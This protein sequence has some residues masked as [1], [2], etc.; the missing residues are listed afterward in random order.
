MQKV[1]DKTEVKEYFNNTGFE[2][3]NKIYSEDGQVNKVQLDIRT[4]HNQTVDRI[5]EWID[6][7]MDAYER[8][9][10]DAG[11]GV[12]SLAIPLTKMGAKKVYASDISKAM[13]TEAR[14][15]ADATLG[16]VLAKNV[17]FETMDLEHIS[18]KFDT[19]FCIDVMIHYPDE[20]LEEMIKH[21]S[22]VAERRMIITFAPYTLA[23][24]LLKQIGSLFPGPS[25]ATRA[26]LHKESDV[27]N[28]LKKL[29]WSVKRTDFISS[30]FYFSK[31]IEVTK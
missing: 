8:T 31:I 19:V 5:L 25:K 11:C 13:V 9:F 22:S 24:G 26:Y 17:E 30:K 23:L 28:I 16:P 2:R 4:G 1:D 21:L 7:D 10:C 27:V 14:Q 6:S 18:G 12:G 3:W 29:G 20:K 15:R